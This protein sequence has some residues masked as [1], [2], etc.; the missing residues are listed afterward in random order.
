VTLTPCT[1]ACLARHRQ[2]QHIELD[3]PPVDRTGFVAPR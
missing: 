3:A 2:Q 1:R